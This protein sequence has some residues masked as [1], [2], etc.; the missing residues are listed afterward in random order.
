MSDEQF[1]SWVVTFVG[2]AGFVLAGRKVWWAWYVN[3]ANQA[4]WVIFALVTGYYAFLIGTAFYL[5]V[6]TR[7][8]YLWTKDHFHPVPPKGKIVGRVLSVT[9]DEHGLTAA[10]QIDD[11][12]LMQHI[13][14]GSLRGLSIGPA[15]VPV[16]DKMSV[17]SLRPP[18]ENS[19]KHLAKDILNEDDLEIKDDYFKE[20]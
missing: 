5:I 11:E 19:L 16:Y 17:D 4:L 13:T 20:K 8:A 1:W 18:G 9:E 10:M 14:R 12:G 2:L 15:V 7:N 6:F 3:I